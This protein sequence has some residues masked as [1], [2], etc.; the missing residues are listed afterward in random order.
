MPC[1]RPVVTRAADVSP[2][3]RDDTSPADAAPVWRLADP[4]DFEALRKSRRRTRCGSLTVAWAPGSEAEPPR[5][6]YAVGRRV[7]GAVVRNRLRRRLRA[8]M[9]ECRPP[10]GHYLV[11]AQPA[12]ASLS[13]SQLKA[14]VSQA[15]QAL[16]EPL[17]GST[18][19]E[20]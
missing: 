19:S 7:G 9:S 20:S 5:V 16:F 14:L 17:S 15:L 3:E 8:V 6:A 13:T 1:S 11:S 4:R 18:G 12:A 10:P 2:P